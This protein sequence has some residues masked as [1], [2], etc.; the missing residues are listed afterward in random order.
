MKNITKKFCL[1]LALVLVCGLTM[2]AGCKPED[3]PNDGD[4]GSLKY[5]RSEELLYAKHFAIDYY[6]EGYRLITIYDKDLAVEAKLLTI[7][8]GKT[9]P[10]DIP[11]NI[12]RLQLPLEN[13]VVSSA[14]VMS[15][16]NAIGCVDKVSMTT[17]DTSTWYIDEVN[18]ALD[19]AE[20]VLIGSYKAPD[21][22][23]M[24][25]KNPPFTVWS[26]MLKGVP[27]VMDQLKTLN[28]NYILDESTNER[29]PLGRTEW[30]KAYG[31]L[32]EK[33]EEAQAAFVA[34]VEKVENIIGELGDKESG[35]KKTVAI[36]YVTSSGKHYLRNGDDYIAAMLEMAGGINVDVEGAGSKGSNST[37][38]TP[39]TFYALVKDA[40]IIIYNFSLG[41]KPDSLED[42]AD[43]LTQLSMFKA[44]PNNIWCTT[45]KFY[46]VTDQMG[47]MA[48]DLYQ[49]MY[50]PEAGDTLEYV[51]KLKSDN[52]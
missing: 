47:S 15:L 26:T 21:Y 5:I 31:V 52:D 51:Y 39:E 1:L 43:R 29:H 30:V 25:S 40:D 42:V 27:E 10:E 7:P 20:M 17:T 49:I 34:Q 38:V 4:L 48:D 22:E 44:Y 16:I 2:L 19:S 32:C 14:P 46:Q 36:C 13:L 9:A 33:E 8:E 35:D 50:N 28:V 37:E 11:E 3:K 12:V 23:T 6:E 24:I 45:P 41:G 18:A